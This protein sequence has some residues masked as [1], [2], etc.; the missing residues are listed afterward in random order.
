MHSSRMHTAHFNSHLRGRGGGG[1]QGMSAPGWG[2]YT[3]QTDTRADTPLLVDK[4]TPVKT[5]PFRNY[6]CGQ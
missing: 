1:V 3:P 6:C 4:Q 5:L 2:V